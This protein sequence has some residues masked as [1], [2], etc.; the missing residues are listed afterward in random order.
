MTSPSYPSLPIPASPAD[1]EMALAECL[2]RA[3]PY[4]PPVALPDLQRIGTCLFS[5]RG[6]LP[7]S[8]YRIDA[9]SAEYLAGDAPAQYVVCGIDGHGVN[10]YAFVYHVVASRAAVFVRIPYEGVHVDQPSAAQDIEIHVAQVAGLMAA[11][12]RA[13]SRGLLASGERVV[14]ILDQQSTWRRAHVRSDTEVDPS[15]WRWERDDTS[16]G[17]LIDAV[18]EILRLAPPDPGPDVSR[19]PAETDLPRSG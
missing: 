14:L 6:S 19:D 9:Y 5:T 8:P 13:E 16:A 3:R 11:L 10:S 4:V 15:L 18:I 2:L 17:T 7:A 1:I 12:E